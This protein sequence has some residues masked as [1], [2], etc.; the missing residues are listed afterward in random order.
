M[1]SRSHSHLLAYRHRHNS[2]CF[3]LTQPHG[4]AWKIHNKELLIRDIVPLYFVQSKYESFTRQLNGWGFKRLHQAGNDFNA[5]Y[6]ECFLKGLPHLTVLMKH[7][8][9]NQG[10]LLPYVDGEPN[11]YDIEQQY[12]LPPRPPA[13]QQNNI[14][15]RTMM[16]MMAPYPSFG[17]GPAS[18]GMPGGYVSG[19]SPYQAYHSASANT[20][21]PFYP[22]TNTMTF[23]PPDARGGFQQGGNVFGEEPGPFLAAATTPGQQMMG[24]LCA[25]PPP[26]YSHSFMINNPSVP[27]MHH[28]LHAS[29]TVKVAAPP[30]AD[31]A[32][33]ITIQNEDHFARDDEE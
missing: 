31:S 12:P 32:R 17:R 18:A 27:L 26:S 6:H 15:N 24:G 3:H 10:K 5:F 16:G 25:P 7:V 20:F 23:P 9:P 1:F 19:F 11:F 33:R 29:T 14:N 2:I 21:P 13:R 22:V 8:P 4:R 28:Q 30:T